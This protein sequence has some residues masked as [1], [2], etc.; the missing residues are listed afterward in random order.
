MYMTLDS[1]GEY[2]NILILMATYILMLTF[3]LLT[4]PSRL[5]AMREVLI[6]STVISQ[7]I[8]FDMVKPQENIQFTTKYI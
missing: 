8:N 7:F 2:L 6:T 5:L 4:I 1:D 3:F